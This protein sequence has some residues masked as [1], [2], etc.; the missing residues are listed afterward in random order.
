MKKTIIIVGCLFTSIALAATENKEFDGS[1]LEILSIKNPSGDVKIGVSKDGK[2]YVAAEKIKFGKNC[3]LKMDKSGRELVVEVSKGGIFNT[4]DCKVNF[5]V[6]VPREIALHLKSGSG[7]LEVN[8]TKGTVDFKI[9][10]GDA[11]VTAEVDTLDGMSGSGSVVAT[12]LS[13]NA[14][15]RTGTG[16]VTLT[17]GSAPSKGELDIKTGSGDATIFFPS[18]M[19]VLT[20]FKAGSGRVYNELGDSEDAR[21]K[22]SMKAGSGDL[23]IKK[24]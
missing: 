22:V 9:G 19:K 14:N 11:K 18:S 10:S 6:K 1:G 13:G 4:D 16:D 17:Y 7:D 2:A 15:V 8:G 20:D 23:K 5:D 21:F 3:T 12:G 24:L